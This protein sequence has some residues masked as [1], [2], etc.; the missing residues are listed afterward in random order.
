MYTSS[1]SC[2]IFEPETGYNDDAG[3][4]KITFCNNIKSQLDATI[5]NFTDNYNQLNMFRA[6]IS[7]ILRSTG[8][9]LQLVV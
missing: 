5:T 2:A 6:I 7:L 3:D 1:V 8:L 4:V 9:C